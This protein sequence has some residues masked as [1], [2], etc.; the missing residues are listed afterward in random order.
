M[1][2][3]YNI[4]LSNNT[5]KVYYHGYHYFYS[6]IIEKFRY[7]N[8][9]MVEI[10]YGDGNS[11]TTWLEYFTYADITVMDINKE[12]V[13]NERCRV[14]KG[15]QSKKSDLERLISKVGKSKLI[16]DDG[17]HNPLHQFNTFEILF[18]N[19]L[20]PGGYYIIE[21]IEVSY[22]H[23]DSTLYGYESGY[24]NLVDAFKKYQEMINSE[25]T[26]VKNHLDISTI[27]FGQ[28]CIIIKKRTEQEKEYFDR[29]YRFSS[30]IDGV[31]HF[32]YPEK[33]VKKFIDVREPSMYELAVKYNTD[34]S[35]HLFP[36]AYDLKLSHL[37]NENI[38]LLEIGLFLG[39]SMKMWC[40][41]FKNGRIYGSDILDEVE[42]TNHVNNLNLY[43][44]ANIPDVDWSANFQFIKL[45]QEDEAALKSFD[46]D[47]DIIVDDGGHSVYQQQLTLKTLIGK[48][49][50]GGYFIIEDIHTSDLVD[51]P[52]ASIVSFGATKNNN[53]I[54][55]L[56]DLK[57]GVLSSDNE[58]YLNNDEFNF[59]YK[60][61][62]T[63]DI[64]K[65]KTDSITSII[66]LK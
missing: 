38:K 3:F 53:T 64:V 8:I 9:K 16:I 25:F 54:K 60:L 65:T 42:M 27:T 39:Y 44:N 62:D 32:E 34:K 31:C 12:M 7:E 17:S 24:F 29:N 13:Y 47:W 46:N 66:K 50:P 43:Q 28:N 4:S 15:D 10:G 26:G 14:I 48:I 56:E 52:E 1:N 21:D 59:V 19:L 22:W 33:E 45:N 11:V 49:K 61:I 36:L 18:K 6:D 30:C 55:L 2:D 63:I 51:N 58:F 57:N 41:Y 20:E 40:D 23:P 37:R 35:Y 5:D